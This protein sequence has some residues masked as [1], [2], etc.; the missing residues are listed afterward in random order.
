VTSETDPGTN[1]PPLVDDDDGGATPAPPGSDRP[2]ALHPRVA[3]IK[4]RREIDNLRRQSAHYRARGAFLLESDEPEV[5]VGF[6]AP[7]VKPAPM[8]FAMKVDYTDYDLQAPSVVFVDPFTAEPYTA[9]TIPTMLKR[10]VEQEMPAGF[11]LIV[12]PPGPEPGQPQPGQ[13][14]PGQPQPR[15]KVRGE[16]NLLVAYG[17]NDIPFLC[18]AGVREYHAHPGHSGDPWELH[19]RTGAGSLTRL[20]EVV[21]SYAVEPIAGFHVELRP[22]V[23]V[24]FGVPP[25]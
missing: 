7:Q 2:G 5:L 17:P 11:P 22:F 21:C 10:G 8:I 13:P 19:R 9:A 16:T 18:L 12:P 3:N 24:D 25:L 15:M 20:V 4:F 1:E 23:S 14:Q 6:A